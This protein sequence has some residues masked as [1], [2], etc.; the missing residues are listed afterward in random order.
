MQS[1]SEY[2]HIFFDMDGTVTRSRSSITEK[3]S[4]LLTQLSD[5]GRNV[6]IISGADL[7]Q[8]EKQV[9]SIVG[10][11]LSQN[12]NHAMVMPGREVLWQ[13]GLTQEERMAIMSHIES[14]PRDWEVQDENDLI[15]DRGSQIAY[16]LIGHN[17]DLDKKE[18][19]D[20]NG[21]RRRVLLEEHPLVS[22][23]VEVRIGGTTT[24]DYIKKGRDKGFNVARLLEQK[25]WNK[26]ECLYIGDALFPGGNDEAVVGVIDTQSVADPTETEKVIKEILST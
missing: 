10:F 12:G 16:S 5:S 26:N 15:S 21:E 6:V 20:S 13:E 18:A 19:F 14:L 9:G 8:I 2:K 25:G 3:M 4:A 11:F 24:L 1:L 23:T 17:E 22:N 7:E